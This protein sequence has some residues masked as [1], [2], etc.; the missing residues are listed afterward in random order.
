MSYLQKINTLLEDTVLK[1]TTSKILQHMGRIRNASSLDLARRW[2][3]ELIQNARDVS[4]EEGIKIRITQTD[5]KLIF[6]HTGRPFRVR[7][8]ISII[9]QASSKSELTESVGKFGTGFVTTFQLSEIVKLKSILFE[10]EEEKAIPFEVILD[11][12]GQ[13]DEEVRKSIEVSMAELR[14]WVRKEESEPFVAGEYNTSFTYD[15]IGNYE[16]KIAETGLN[17]LENSVNEILL[18]SD[19]IKEICVEIKTVKRRKTTVYKKQSDSGFSGMTPIFESVFL[20]EITEDR[21]KKTEQYKMLEISDGSLSLAVPVDFEKNILPLDEKKARLYVD[22]PLVGSENFPFPVI[23]NDRKLCSNEERSGISLVDSERSFEARANKEIML[24]AVKLYGV[25]FRY[26]LSQRYG[27]LW[28][29]IRIPVW[30]ENPE[31]SESWVRAN[32]YNALYRVFYRE[33]IIETNVGMLSLSNTLLRFA[34]SEDGEE[35]DNIYKLMSRISK[36]AIAKTDVDWEEV[37]H[38]YFGEGIDIVRLDIFSIL[39]KARTYLL[40]IK[41]EEEAYS[42]LNDLYK[43]AMKNEEAVLAIKS[44]GIHLFPSQKPNE[45]TVNKNLHPYTKMRK[46]LSKD[47]FLREI[48]EHLFGEKQMVDFRASLVDKKLKLT[49]EEMGG[50]FDETMASYI[51]NC[52]THITTYKTLDKIS[53]SSQIA[54]AKLAEW[55]DTMLEKNPSKAWELFPSFCSEEGR[56]KLLSPKAVAAINRE[57]RESKVEISKLVEEKDKLRDETNKLKEELHRLKE[58]KSDSYLEHFD[59]SILEAEIN[60]LGEDTDDK[61]REIGNAGENYALKRLKD[62]YCLNL[63]EE[64]LFM[65]TKGL[66]KD[67]GLQYEVCYMDTET[68]KQA[69]FDI[70]VIGRDALGT[71]I[72]KDYFEVKTHSLGS[73]A[74][75]RLHF[76]EEQMKLAMAKGGHYHALKVSYDLNE[77]KCKD[78]EVY[79]NVTAKISEGLLRHR[80]RGYEYYL[81]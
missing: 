9:N 39:E 56:A 26:L 42:W 61:L 4:Y 80:V 24:K 81:E 78:M 57:L 12:R 11:R 54:C 3:M 76:S 16:K 79:Q 44:G 29:M 75:N 70:L 14:E 66:E 37:L 60:L 65:K 10:E 59:V 47:E 51:N 15:L 69:G 73:I 17:D 7:D 32:I 38:G 68:Y 21:K 28:N 45:F 19:R 49:D 41:E 67:E 77:G 30:E 6:E 18:F 23:L 22:F 55:I 48:A 34:A 33:H 36:F 27:K 46:D 62:F 35:K 63:P 31:M 71:E 8:I 20:W 5:E 1:N 64:T 74:K 40:T 2:V 25:L 58:E 53:P 52:V 13:N 50:F 72:T 43:T